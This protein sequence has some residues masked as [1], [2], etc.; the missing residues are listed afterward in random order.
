MPID[1]P[2]ETYTQ[3]DIER[4]CVVSEIRKGRSYVGSVSRLVIAPQKITAEVQGSARWPYEVDISFFRDIAGQWSPAMGCSCPVGIGCKHA[5]ATLLAAVAARGQADRINPQIFFW[6][7]TLREVQ[8]ALLRPARRATTEQLFY[9]LQ[10][11]ARQHQMMVGMRKGRPDADGKPARAATDWQNIER[12]LH[13][14]PAFV[15]TRDID[16]LRIL[17]GQRP[18]GRDWEPI[19]ISERA[20]GDCLR[21]LLATGRAFFVGAKTLSALKEDIARE[22]RLAWQIDSAGRLLAT[23]GAGKTSLLVMPGTPAWYL[24]PSD[25]SIGPLTGALPPSVLQHLLNLPPLGRRDRA[26]VAEAMRELLPDLPVPAEDAEARLHEIGGPPQPTLTLGTLQVWAVRHYRDYGNRHDLGAFDYALPRFRYGD[27][28]EI[29]PGDKREFIV[30]PNGETIRLRR[31]TKAEAAALAKLHDAGLEPLPARALE[32]RDARAMPDS[33]WGLASEEAWPAFVERG[34]KAL[35][36]KGWRVAIP[37][38]FRHQRLEVEA[39]HADVVDGGG[40]FELDLG[41]TV[42]GR[43]LALPPLL[44]ELFARD[45]RWLDAK[46][47]DRIDAA[48]AIDLH[49]PEGDLVRV[50]A[51]RIKPLARTLI[52]L[53]DRKSEGPL[54]LPALDAERLAAFADDVRWQFRGPDS[55][56]ALADKLCEAGRPHL[57]DAPAGFALEL[58]GYQREGLG[59][60]QY[61]R[62]QNLA[63]ILADDMGLGKTAQTLAHLLVEKHAGRMDRPT[64]IVLPTSLVFNWRREAA[65]CAPELRVLVLHGPER[66]TRFDA[67]VHNDIVLT[68]YP[69]V[70][71]DAEVLRAQLWHLLILDEAQTVKNAASKAA[72]TLR[73]LEAR[74]RL[75]I[76]GTPLENHLGELWSQFDFLLPGFLGTQREFTKHWR[77]P[78]E[79]HGDALR[80][81]LLARRLK[82]FILRRRKEEVAT[83]LPPKSLVLRSVAFDTAQR[84]LYETVRAAVDAAVQREIAAKGFRRS[85][86]VILDA[87]LKLRQVC[88]D[89]RLLK[90]PGA[91][92]VKQ[93]AKLELLLEMLPELISEG[94]RVLLFSQFTGMLDLI[95]AE[96][97]QAK[98]AFVR[99]DG[100]TR[101]RETPVRRFQDNEVPLFLI[102]LKAGGVG[103]NLTAA[104]T[105][106]HFD[107]WWN[108]AAENQAT[109]RAHRIG[110]TRNVFVYKLVVAGSIEERIVALQ[111]KKAELA[112]SILGEDQD[113]EIKFSE[114]DLAALLAPL[115]E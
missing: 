81:E 111:E 103:L 57:T 1:N 104:D 27:D 87:L 91:Q 93:S 106:I 30:Q 51:E 56:R 72:G 82:P 26:L 11:D 35:A 16:A 32:P 43:R 107:P 20:T 13:A 49:L 115:P 96:L 60:L 14:P 24:D 83:E 101:D 41:I 47:L 64:L 67:I 59:W 112:A 69:L 88:C 46:R 92:R 48:E 62:A 15:D 75:C 31:D 77:T 25:A 89:P 70:W 36:L 74:H 80:R 28:I 86:I 53:F 110:Q 71:R 65:R 10:W 68:T 61:L 55:L 9:V 50:V 38:G 3:R 22:V 58:R 17:W 114:N 5:A 52:D 29:A 33:L 76:T 105:V 108:P 95:E 98:L 79:K 8:K 54:R 19:P 39:W 42:E 100:R 40:W 37:A 66:A 102:S 78:I 45:A 97:A 85:Q 2:A 4:W 18:R 73:T 6:I 113:G 99:L 109:D 12:A 7:E 90:T 23:F 44:A 63:G 34:A 84:D 21:A 94:R